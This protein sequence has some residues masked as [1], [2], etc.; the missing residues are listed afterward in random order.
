M[1]TASAPRW[2]G[3]QEALHTQTELPP[4]DRPVEA[5]VPGA[6]SW[7]EPTSPREELGAHDDAARPD[8]SVKFDVNGTKEHFYVPDSRVDDLITLLSQV[9]STVAIR[10]ETGD[11][12]GLT[13]HAD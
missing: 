11:I 12:V 5:S 6:H 9:R 3:R 2:P 8:V 10:P 13:R 4:A 7:I 1:L